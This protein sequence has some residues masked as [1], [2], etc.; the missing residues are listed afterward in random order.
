MS[1]SAVSRLALLVLG[2]GLV[3]PFGTSAAEELLVKGMGRT[4]GWVV[5]ADTRTLAFR[6]C[7]G[8]LHTTHDGRIER[9]GQRCRAGVRSE[10]GT[11]PG[12]L[13]AIDAGKRIVGLQAADG[14]IEA[15]YYP[16]AHTGAKDEGPTSL[17]DL[18]P[19]ADVLVET[20]VPG[21]AEAIRRR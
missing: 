12:T 8:R 13:V 18:E 16:P 1:E 9:T 17:V 20:R 19:G 21:R 10:A 4:V 2:L 14:A 5:A 6:D 11:V 7:N 3:I 15:Y